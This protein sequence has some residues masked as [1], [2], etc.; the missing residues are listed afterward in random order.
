MD[1]GMSSVAGGA[2]KQ[3][4]DILAILSLVA[5]VIGLLAGLFSDISSF[6]AVCCCLGVFGV[7]AGGALGLLLALVGVVLGIVSLVRIKKAP[8]ELGGKGL[9]IGGILVSLVAVVASLAAV[10]L[11]ALVYFGMLALN[12]S[13]GYS[14]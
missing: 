5:G 2:V 1:Q 8:D 7:L 13:Q 4:T 12:A 9:A 10:V 6:F 3:R 14:Y 11:W